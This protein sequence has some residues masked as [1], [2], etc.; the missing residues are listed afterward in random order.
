[1]GE[2]QDAVVAASFLSMVSAASDGENG[3]SGFTYGVLV[4]NELNR[5]AEIRE[6]LRNQQPSRSHARPSAIPPTIKPRPRARHRSGCDRRNPR[7]PWS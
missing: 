5:A 7:P 1:M 4:A 6:S 3:G 2:H